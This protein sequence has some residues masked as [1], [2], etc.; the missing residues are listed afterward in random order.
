MT[1]I[2]R[3][4][5]LAEI[6]RMIQTARKNLALTE[7]S[8]VFRSAVQD[9]LAIL[10]AIA[11]DLKRPAVTLKQVMDILQDH[12]E[13]E[14]EEGEPVRILGIAT[15]AEAIMS[16]AGD[17]PE[18]SSRLTETMNELASACL[19]LEDKGEH[20]GDHHDEAC[21]IC[22]VLSKATALISAL[23]GNNV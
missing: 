11:E 19:V 23:E 21:D 7:K 5:K 3:P 15:T 8:R 17:A 12:I 4:A 20:G 10:E 1:A 6:E 22:Q 9:R 13:I 16:L 18:R 2:D 14:H